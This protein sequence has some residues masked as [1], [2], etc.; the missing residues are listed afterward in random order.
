MLAKRA[1]KV[2][3]EARRWH[4]LK[5]KKRDYDKCWTAANYLEPGRGLGVNL[6]RR[7]AVAWTK[8]CL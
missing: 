6:S 1:Q 5:K 3:E 4:C 8:E 7:E 2:E